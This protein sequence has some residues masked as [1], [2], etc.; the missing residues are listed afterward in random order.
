LG[1][2]KASSKTSDEKKE[3]AVAGAAYSHGIHRFTSIDP[4]L[5]WSDLKYVF[6]DQ[7]APD[8]PRK[9]YKPEEIV[10]KLRQVDVQ[11]SQ[12]Q[13][14]GG[15]VRHCESIAGDVAV[16]VV[17]ESSSM[18]KPSMV[19]DLLAPVYGWF[20]GLLDKLHAWQPIS[21]RSLKELAA[22]EQARCHPSK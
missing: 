6:W 5:K 2:S 14:T 13:G 11:V 21:K 7:G 16:A 22:S 17:G 10:A 1:E 4:P 18:P 8:F 19:S 12:G 3:I 15:A 20:T 9:T